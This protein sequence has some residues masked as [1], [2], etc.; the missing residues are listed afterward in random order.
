[1]TPRHWGA[2]GEPVSPNKS[3]WQVIGA[4][5]DDVGAEEEATAEEVTGEEFVDVETEVAAA[6][7]ELQ[8]EDDAQGAVADEEGPQSG[9]KNDM[10]SDD[11]E[12]RKAKV[13]R[14]PRAPTKHEIETHNASHLPTA[15]W[16]PYCVAGKGVSSPM[17]K[18]DQKM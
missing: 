6:Q 7:R 16:C 10:D 3:D 9:I 17:D 1:M 5:G 4:F 2:K 14:R 13:M 12:Y 8:G 11:A 18:E 15:D